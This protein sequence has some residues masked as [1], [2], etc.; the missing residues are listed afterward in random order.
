MAKALC[1]YRDLTG[2]AKKRIRELMMYADMIEH[3]ADTAF[4][5]AGADCRGC[6][7]TVFMA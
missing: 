3:R 7:L 4:P 2:I 1:F 6:A 5:Q